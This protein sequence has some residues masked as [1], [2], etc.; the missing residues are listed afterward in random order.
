MEPHR[1]RYEPIATAAGHV[2]Y[3]CRDCC[4]VA[5]STEAAVLTAIRGYHVN[6]RSPWKARP[7]ASLV[8]S[9]Q[10]TR[11]PAAPP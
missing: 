7:A 9:G 11:P 3:S 4:Q 6:P 5:T 8:D 2:A 10:T 1:H